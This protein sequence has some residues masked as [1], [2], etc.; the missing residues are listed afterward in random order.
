VITGK[1]DRLIPPANS[2]LLAERI[3][4]AVLEE[5]PGGHLFTT[6]HPDLFNRRV[7]E[8]V[9]GVSGSDYSTAKLVR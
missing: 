9:L 6:E 8:F 1:E 4:G 2:R 3:P 7:V 5:L